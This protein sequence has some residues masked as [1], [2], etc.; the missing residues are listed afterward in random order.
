MK[1][2][3]ILLFLLIGLQIVMAGEIHRVDLS[4]KLIHVIKIPERDVIRF[5]W[6]GKEQEIMIK[7]VDS[8]GVSLTIFI[9]GSDVPYYAKLDYNNFLNLDF[10]RDRN[11][12][13]MVSVNNMEGNT[14]SLALENRDFESN[15]ITG[16]VVGASGSSSFGVIAA[17]LV[18]V[19]LVVFFFVWRKKR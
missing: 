17:I 13:I 1:K 15:S 3:L 4:D 10:N 14:V 5:D 11:T 18:L 16:N 19:V 2:I 9:E 6:D 7:S 8:D 12:D